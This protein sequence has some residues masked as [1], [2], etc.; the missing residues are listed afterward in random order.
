[1]R[2]KP[3]R[4]EARHE[5]PRAAE[6]GRRERPVREDQPPARR[7]RTDDQRT[8]RRATNADERASRRDDLGTPVLGFGDEAP[9]FMMLRR[10][11]RKAAVP[12]AEEVPA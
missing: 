12:V 9:A 6:H 8:P 1:M 3:P 5:E 10:P 4:D 2:A 11:A 7:R